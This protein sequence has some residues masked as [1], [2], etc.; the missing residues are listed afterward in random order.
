MKNSQKVSS[1]FTFGS[2]TALFVGII[3]AKI[4]EMAI[5]NQTL[6]ILH[7]EDNPVDALLTRDQ[8]QAK[9]VTAEITHVTGRS[10]F[11][12][13]LRA[14]KWDLVLSDYHVPN[15]T[16]IEALGLVRREFPLMPFILMSG[17][18]GEQA[19]IESLRAGATD[20]VLKQN[21]ERLPAAVRRAVV[22][23]K[24]HSRREQAEI[25][26]RQSEKQ[27]RL[28][29]NGNPH[30]MWVFD[31]ESLQVLEV[32]EAAV[33][34]YGYSHDEFLAMSL[35]DLRVPVRTQADENSALETESRGIVWRR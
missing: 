35:A 7:L 25:D 3:G 24:E 11:E 4:R 32:N 8:L 9:G 17:T 13:A 19:A 20:Y 5:I 28:L 15:F 26:L 30:P 31:L 6:R 18:I 21:R 23:A 29:F 16:G 14:E 33:E 34:H 1:R 22:E 27:Y 12:R 10:E 2:G